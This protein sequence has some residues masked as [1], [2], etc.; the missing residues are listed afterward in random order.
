M[1]VSVLGL[2]ASPLGGAFGTVSE[3]EGIRTIHTAIEL[4]INFID[5][6]PYYS[7]THAES[8][9]GKALKEIPRER[10]LLATKVGRYG[11]T[12]DDF[13]FSSAR[14]V[15]SVDESLKRLG[16]SHIDLIQCQDVE[17]A[18]W[19]QL[20]QDT[21]PALEKLK[22]TGKVRH[23]GITAFPLEMLKKT[24]D[25]KAVETVLS[26]C[27]YCLT[28]TTL[29]RILSHVKSKG[30]GVINA[31]PYAM[32]LLTEKGPPAWHP[33]TADYRDV[34]ANAVNHCVKKRRNIAK[35]A[36]QFSVSN[37]DVSTTLVGTSNPKNLKHAVKWV[38]EPIEEDLLA[39]V[40]SL[41]K[42]ILN[43]PWHGGREKKA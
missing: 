17:F 10:F 5:V 12:P 31:S 26:Y 35:L 37:R 39:E 30:T 40:Q 11:P 20:V 24:A 19:P 18:P 13:D 1:K 15:R 9:L 29:V 16:V 4:G 6:A 41:L 36:L 38:G 33:A 42:P 28:D 21:L 43:Q 34:C 7:S 25:L 14:V 2:G 23:V 22:T 27:R 3:K 8:I 32:G